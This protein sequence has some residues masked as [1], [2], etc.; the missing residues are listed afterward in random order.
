MENNTNSKKLGKPEVIETNPH[1]SLLKITLSGDV[2]EN[3]GPRK[4]NKSPTI[5]LKN[6]VLITMFLIWIYSANNQQNSHQNSQTVKNQLGY[7]KF[8][9]IKRKTPIK[10]T[11]S[12]LFFILLLISNDIEQNPGPTLINCNICHL[13]VKTKPK[14]ECNTC[15]KNYHKICVITKNITST[16]TI[17]WICPEQ[18][19]APNLVKPQKGAALS[20]NRFTVLSNSTTT[21]SQNVNNKNLINA[22]LT[23]EELENLCYLNELPSISPKEYI[24]EPIC[25]TCNRRIR[26]ITQTVTCLK[27]NHYTHIRCLKACSKPTNSE[28]NYTWNCIKCRTAE[29]IIETTFDKSSCREEQLPENWNEILKGKNTGNDII[30]HYNCRSIVNKKDEF[31]HSMN[32]IKPAIIFLSETWFDD[33]CPKG[34][35]VPNEYNIIRKDRSEKFKQKYGKKN[36]GGI[37]ILVRK[38]VKLKI[39][40]A[41]ETDPEE[42]LCCNLY[43]KTKKYN[44]IFVYRANYTDILKSDK[45]GGTKMEQLLQNSGDEETIVIGDLNCDV[46][47]KH[48]NKETQKLMTTC[49]EYNF[50]QLIEKPT[51]ISEK[52]ATTIDHIWTRKTNLITKTGTCEGLSDHCGIY[53]FIET[54]LGKQE[55]EEITFRDF[56]MFNEDKYKSDIQEYIKLSDFQKHMDNKDVNKAFDTWVTAL[57]RA[58]DDNAP[59]ITRKN[60]NSNNKQIPWYNK[61]IEEITKTKNMYLELFKLYR[62]PEDKSSI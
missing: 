60:S 4:I 1:L 33:S 8:S 10:S 13:P 37:A 57:Q 48:P 25:R 12:Y 36:G 50:K 47:A 45:D 32:K 46:N 58:A 42:I 15:G 19:C 61:E 53:A 2:E 7:V 16:T 30:I 51:R 26:K 6:I 49:E 34:M 62:N 14:L 38:G 21:D 31:I 59:L 17:Q 28:E 3:P 55:Q 18:N 27:C 35:A 39:D 29:E 41:K 43:T 40:N 24:G 52:T 23:N 56:R 44:I 9:L 11:S 5:H 20:K 22:E 54:N